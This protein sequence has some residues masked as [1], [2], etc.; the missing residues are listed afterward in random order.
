MA[1]GAAL[2]LVALPLW[3]SASTLLG[4]QAALAGIAPIASPAGADSAQPQLEPG[5][6][7][8]VKTARMFVGSGAT[9]SR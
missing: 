2:A 5:S 4:S 6:T 7:S 9:T 1:N 3:L 8:T